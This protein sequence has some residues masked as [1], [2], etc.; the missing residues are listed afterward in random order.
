[1]TTE[2]IVTACTHA[3]FAALMAVAHVEEIVL[4]EREKQRADLWKAFGVP[5]D[6]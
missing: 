1:M 2:M 6:A 4:P 5:F 3:Y